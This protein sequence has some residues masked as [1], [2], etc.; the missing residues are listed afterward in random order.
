MDSF[1]LA[2][3]PRRLLPDDVVVSV[4]ADVPKNPDHSALELSDKSSFLL[5]EPSNLLTSGVFPL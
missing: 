5:E 2:R 1:S 3:I 4:V